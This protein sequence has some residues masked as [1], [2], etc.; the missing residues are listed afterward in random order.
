MNT[1]ALEKLGYGIYL[2]VSKDEAQDN[3]CIT[4]CV[5]QV[6]SGEVKIVVALNKRNLT[7]DMILKNK[8]FNVCILTEETQFAF[9]Q[10]FGFL[11]GRD[12]EKFK[13]YPHAERAK[14]GILYVTDSANAYI[15]ATVLETVDVGSHTLF[16]AEV[17]DTSVFSDAPAATY[18]YYH[19]NIKAKS[20]VVPGKKGELDCH[21]K[22]DGNYKEKN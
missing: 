7:H 15:S 20:T 8:T 13:D 18:A 9:I 4:N 6:T 1:A 5:M 19:S 22:S 12:C 3:G 21:K 14:N 11:S 10:R 17:T 2:I 16:I